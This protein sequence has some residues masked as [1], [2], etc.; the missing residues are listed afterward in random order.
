M[1]F[2]YLYFEI[3]LGSLI[4]VRTLTLEQDSLGPG[5]T[6]GGLL[7]Q[8]LGLQ[9]APTVRIHTG[10]LKYLKFTGPRTLGHLVDS[11][12]SKDGAVRLSPA[13]SV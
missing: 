5:T 8:Q 3:T 1:R 10:V 12:A 2:L 6:S 11:V 9:A 7:L 4:C 13:S